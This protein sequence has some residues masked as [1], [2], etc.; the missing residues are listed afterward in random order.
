MRWKPFLL[1]LLL[2]AGSAFLGLA[3][4]AAWVYAANTGP[5]PGPLAAGVNP[6]VVV[7]PWQEG[8][9]V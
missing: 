3:A 4:F 9:C 8:R 6:Q 5:Q 7:W 1:G 2:V